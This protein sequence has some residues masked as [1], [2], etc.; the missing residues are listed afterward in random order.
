MGQKEWSK[1]LFRDST[2]TLDILVEAPL[3]TNTQ[4]GILLV[5]HT[6]IPP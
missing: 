4:S 5:A 6:S 2:M 3:S 1:M